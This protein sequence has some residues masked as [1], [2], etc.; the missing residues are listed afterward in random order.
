MLT[1]TLPWNIIV[2]AGG[3]PNVPGIWNNEQTIA[4]KKVTD[5]QYRLFLRR[6]VTDVP[7]TGKPKPRPLTTAESKNT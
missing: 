7:I 3:L 6:K 5:A 4:L 1:V 2:N